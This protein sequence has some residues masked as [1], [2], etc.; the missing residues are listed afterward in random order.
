MICILFLHYIYMLYCGLQCSGVVLLIIW[1]ST[2]TISCNFM[3]YVHVKYYK[4]LKAEEIHSLIIAQN[5]GMV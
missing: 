1:G 5:Y 2:W 4:W 3:F